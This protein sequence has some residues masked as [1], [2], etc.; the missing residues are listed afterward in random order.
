MILSFSHFHPLKGLPPETE[1]FLGAD[2]VLRARAILSVRKLKEI[3]EAIKIINWLIEQSPA[4]GLALKQLKKE[5][6]ASGKRKHAAMPLFRD[7]GADVFSLKMCMGKFDISG[8]EGF[9]RATWPEL[10]AVL[11]LALI[12][13]AADSELHHDKPSTGKKLPYLHEY[14]KLSHVSPWLTYAAAAVATAEGMML[15]EASAKGKKK[16]LSLRSQADS[17]ELHHKTILAV[18]A[19]DNYYCSG[20]FKSLKNAARMF[21]EDH[22]EKVAHLAPARRIKT[23]SEGLSRQLH[24]RGAGK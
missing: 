2:I 22:P 20:N 8:H 24:K 19:L 9:P 5:A 12:N 7:F 6:A 18:K 16:K 13:E 21:I 3:R 1:H 10:F 15:C 4:N 17:I 11:A 23:L 14:R